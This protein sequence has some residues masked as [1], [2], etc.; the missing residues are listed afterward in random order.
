ML[1]KK[2][3]NTELVVLSNDDVETSTIYGMIKIYENRG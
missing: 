2:Y 1:L 3:T